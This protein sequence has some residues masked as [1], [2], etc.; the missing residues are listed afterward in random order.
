MLVRSRQDVLMRNPFLLVLPLVL[1]LAVLPALG[2]GQ[3]ATPF[4]IVFDPSRDVEE[5]SDGG[6]GLQFT[7]SF[8]VIRH[9]GASE[10]KDYKIVVEEDGREV[11]RFDVP[12]PAAAEADM[13]VAVPSGA[14]RAKPLVRP[15]GPG[16]VEIKPK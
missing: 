12:P 8:K 9:K 4:E 13:Y 2:Q 14:M 10:G 16:V 11:A 3:P 15:N 7:V 5:R 1:A 6:K